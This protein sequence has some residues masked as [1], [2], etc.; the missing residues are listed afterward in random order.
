MVTVAF[1]S[2]LATILLNSTVS[3]AE[4]AAAFA[5][6]ALL[7]Y[8]VAALSTLW[9]SSRRLLTTGPTLLLR[10]GRPLPEAMRDQRIT[11]G[12]LCQ[13]VRSAG[14]GSLGDVA[15]V[16]LESD[17]TLSVVPRSRLGDGSALR[18]VTAGAGAPPS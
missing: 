14:S 12:E 4:G 16:V 18:D 11:P 15:A 3:W 1:G 6:L 5:V 2:T 7:Q 17:G 8:V 9:P 13:A 10:D